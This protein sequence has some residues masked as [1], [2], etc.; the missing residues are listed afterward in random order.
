M[1]FQGIQLTN[2]NKNILFLRIY[3]NK[4]AFQKTILY[5]KTNTKNHFVID[6]HF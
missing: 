1:F 3:N 5:I 4:F 2:V 6:N